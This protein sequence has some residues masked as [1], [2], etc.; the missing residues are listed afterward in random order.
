MDHRDPNIDFVKGVLVIVMV[1]Y[2]VMN[3]FANAPYEY[4]GYLRFINGAFVFAAGYV[5]PVVYGERYRLDPRRVSKRLALRGFKLL[6]LFTILNVLISAIGLTSYKNVEFSLGQYVRNLP[7]IYGPGDGR[8]MAFQILVPIS[9]TLI[10]SPILLMQQERKA[11]VMAATLTLPLLY[12]TLQLS[13]PNLFF[14]MIGLIGLSIGMIFDTSK[15]YRVRN[16]LVIAAAIVGLAFVIDYVSGNALTYSLGIAV[17][18][19]LIYDIADLLDLKKAVWKPVVMTGQY[20]LLC[21]IAQIVFLYTLYIVLPKQKWTFGYELLL[22]TVGA[23]IFLG[24]L[25]TV[26]DTLRQRYALVDRTYR[27]VFA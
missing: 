27:W 18:L 16:W 25:C 23:T 5:V 22:I 12:A 3:Y 11:L 10:I 4:Y 19:L 7:V 15:L 26:L 21:Y 1:I 8:L 6:A 13:A 17:G 9:Y 14:V 24:I 2:H 20:S